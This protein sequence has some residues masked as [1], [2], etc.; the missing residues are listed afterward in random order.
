MLKT[1]PSRKVPWVP[2]DAASPLPYDKVPSVAYD[3]DI[4]CRPVIETRS[5]ETERATDPLSGG[6]GLRCAPVPALK[7]QRIGATT[8]DTEYAGSPTRVPA[9]VIAQWRKVHSPIP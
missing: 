3:I 7:P 8:R 4:T 5:S 9:L 2:R 1:S 6:P